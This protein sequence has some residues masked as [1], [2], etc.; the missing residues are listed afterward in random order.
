MTASTA[1]TTTDAQTTWQLVSWIVAGFCA[2]LA[3]FLSISQIRAHH[4]RFSQPTQQRK[5]V[6]ILWIVPIY[7]VNSWLSLRYV[8]ASVYIDAFRDCYEAYVLH[9]FLSLMYT[10]LLSPDGNP[11]RMDDILDN[12]DEDHQ[13]VHH[14]FPFN[15]LCHP[16]PV[17]AQF[18]QICYRGTLQ[19]MILKPI[20][21]LVAVIMETQGIYHEGSFSFSYGYIYTAIVMN[22]SITWAAYVL[23]QFYLVFKLQLKPYSPVPKFLCIK[24]ILFL[25]FWQAVVLAGFAQFELIHDI[26]EY[27][28]ADVKTGINNLLLCVEMVLIAVAHRY[29]FPYAQYAVVPSSAGAAASETGSVRGGENQ[30]G[31]SLLNDN[32]A[33]TDLL[34]DVNNSGMSIVV[35]TGFTPSSKDV[36]LKE[37]REEVEEVEEVVEVAVEGG[38]RGEEESGAKDGGWR[39]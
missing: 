10:Y 39:L 33:T 31:T 20:T 3:T 11:N 22:C 35:P 15:Y 1:S 38:D 32:F 14:V 8:H 29:A 18:L 37:G 25:S 26:G 13:T 19:F 17:D 9:M 24:A 30:L 16:W 12:M 6:A 27:T 34:R 4:S 21:T 5:I 7:A 2:A 36:V 28:A 23:L